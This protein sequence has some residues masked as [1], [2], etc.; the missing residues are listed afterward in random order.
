[1]KILVFHI[2]PTLETGGAETMLKNLVLNSTSKKFIHKIITLK[3]SQFDSLLFKENNIE[4]INLSFDSIISSFQSF[5][6]LLK[7]VKF[8]K[9]AI[10]QSW[11]YHANILISLCSIFSRDINIVWN[12]RGNS[13]P[14]SKFSLTNLFVILG[15]LF[16]HAS[17][18]KIVCC[19]YSVQETHIKK[20]YKKSKMQVI[21]NGYKLSTFEVRKWREKIRNELDISRKIVIGVLGRY[22]KLKDYKNFINAAEII[23]KEYKYTNIKFLMIG[24]NLDNNDYLSGLINAKNMTSFFITVGHKSNPKTYLDAIDIYCSS[25]LSEGF[26]NALCEAMAMEKTCVVTNAGDSKII[27][28]G[29][30]EVVAVADPIALAES[31]AKEI[32]MSDVDRKKIGK[33]MRGRISE[34]YA[35]EKIVKKYESL[36]EGVINE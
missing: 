22:D 1:M 12:L 16:S 2:I 8:N 30:S 24:S 6:E 36:Y 20:G 3:R 35:I 13:I 11:M 25:S 10:F 18:K 17:P 23:T 31:L 21:T 5:S 7:I 28:Q 32:S 19:A 27:L 33:E 14:Q 9:E 26:P 4:V 29:I 15:A 34:Q